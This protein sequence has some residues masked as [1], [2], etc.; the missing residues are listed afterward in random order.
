MTTKNFSQYPKA[1]V[2]ANKDSLLVQLTTTNAPD[3]RVGIEKLLGLS[4]DKPPIPSKALAFYE[5]NGYWNFEKNVLPWGSTLIKSIFSPHLEKFRYFSKLKVYYIYNSSTGAFYEVDSEMFRAGLQRWLGSTIYSLAE[6]INGKVLRLEKEF[7]TRVDVVFDLPKPDPNYLCLKNGLLNKRNKTLEKHTPSVFVT[8]ACHYNYEPDATCPEFLKFLANFCDDQQDRINLV[9]SFM[10]AVLHNYTDPQIFLYISGPG[11]TGKS[12][13]AHVLSSLL[14]PES[15]TSTSLKNLNTDRYEVLNIS[16]KSLVVL[17]D[18]EDYSG[19]MS[20]LKAF[21]GQD[22][23]DGNRKFVQGNFPVI[24]SGIV[25]ILANHPFSSSRDSGGALSRRVIPFDASRISKSRV[26]LIH[27]KFPEGYSGPLWSEVSGI[28][29][30]VLEW[31]RVEAHE[32]LTKTILM[33]PSLE[34]H[35]QEV[36]VNLSP[37][38]T[39]VEDWL[40]PQKDSQVLVGTADSSPSTSLFSNYRLHVKRFGGLPLSH[41]KFVNDLKHHLKSQHWDIDY[42][43][44]S[45]GRVFQGVALRQKEPESYSSPN[46]RDGDGEGDDQGKD[47]TE[48]EEPETTNLVVNVVESNNSELL[49]QK[50]DYLKLYEGYIEYL[51]TELGSNPILTKVTEITSNW[52]KNLQQDTDKFKKVLDRYLESLGLCKGQNEPQTKGIEKLKK[53]F[54]VSLDKVSKGAFGCC[55]YNTS[56]V[57]PRIFPKA[58]TLSGNYFKKAFKTISLESCSKCLHEE[59]GWELIDLDLKSCYVSLVCAFFPNLTL[60]LR[61]I[62]DSA[63]LWDYL[64]TKMDTDGKSELFIKPRCKIAVYSSYFGGSQR[65]MVDSILEDEKRK[66]FLTPEEWVQH[67]DYSCTREQASQLASYLNCSELLM[68]FRE[69]SDNLRQELRDIVKGNR[70]E[71]GGTSSLVFKGPLGFQWP[72][73][74]PAWRC[75]YSCILQELEVL[76]VAGTVE[77]LRHKKSPHVPHENW[78]VIMH[79]HDGIVLAVKSSDKQ[80]LLKEFN[81]EVKQVGQELGAQLPEYLCWESQAFCTNH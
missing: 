8:G 18:A 40:I 65:A 63:G 20:I 64:K 62:L 42:K 34:V 66:R 51:N 73:D 19:D 15:V 27:P 17:N 26:P 35:I 22:K 48:K 52:A 16:C 47:A 55:N 4:L 54:R 37:L 58:G 49:K 3:Q 2:A 29:N 12:I 10:W 24:P 25:L 9:R 7:H 31:D 71:K 77:R 1:V 33:V 28:L 41:K 56:S 78:R 80:V 23:L 57:S 45:H 38:G 5:T 14:P 53:N 13:F 74:A 39:W 11:S 21:V 59:M 50:P 32:Y 75:S 30:W 44:V 79:C 72:L 46:H 6:E 70:R 68:T 36:R 76:L 67:P 81:R 60:R 61:N 69:I 43:R